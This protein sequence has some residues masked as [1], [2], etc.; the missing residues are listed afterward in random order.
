MRFMNATSVNVPR[1][2]GAALL[3]FTALLVLISASVLLDRLSNRT[4]LNTDR[5]L[6]TTA[7]LA[8]A[9]AALIAWSVT[10]PQTPGRL[11]YPDRNKDPAGYDGI[12][13]CITS[14][15]ILSASHLLGRLP[16]DG[17]YSP[18]SGCF[19]LADA[20]L[21]IEVKDAGGEPLWY[22]VSANLVVNSG[23]TINPGLFD[24]AS[25][26]Y[27]WLRVLDQNGN[28]ISDRAA[29]VV[30]AP[31]EAVRLENGVE[32]DRS[33]PAPDPVE[34]LDRVTVDG[35]T[36]DNSDND[37]VFIQYPDSRF[38]ASETDSFNDRLVYITIDELMRKVEKRVL[39]DAAV[40][41]QDY[42]ATRGRYPWLSPY[43]DPT[44]PAA[45]LATVTG[46]LESV[47]GKKI[48]D[49]DAD[50][51]N[52]GVEGGHAVVNVSRRTFTTVAN[53]IGPAQLELD[54]D[55]GFAAGHAYNVLP[56][57]NGI[58]GQREG[59]IPF[60]DSG[61]SYALAT[62]FSATW[63]GGAVSG[64]GCDPGFPD[65]PPGW[66]IVGGCTDVDAGLAGAAAG[67][68]SVAAP[69]VP[70]P[71]ADNGECIWTDIDTVD[72]KGPPQTGDAGYTVR[73]TCPPPS[74]APGPPAPEPVSRSY[75]VSLEFSGKDGQ[76]SN[77][78]NVKT[79][80]VTSDE[81]VNIQFQD[82]VRGYALAPPHT[83]TVPAESLT[84]DGI[85]FDI[86]LVEGAEF[87][88]YFFTNFW[89]RYI[90][91]KISDEHV[92][93]NDAGATSSD[94]CTAGTDCVSLEI[95][96]VTVRNE[97]QALVVGAGGELDRDLTGQNRENGNLSDYFESSNATQ[98]DDTAER[99]I[100][101]TV[102]NDQVRVIQPNP[103]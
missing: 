8:E 38:T 14:P 3:V 22:A 89:H 27:P 97:I 61:E 48:T 20:R 101:T 6:E 73:V 17:E 4:Q 77:V 43:R 37:L 10:H 92:A 72:C 2:A 66:N 83:V 96:G 81:D 100:L 7:A 82:S 74:C 39:G 69:A 30:I 56:A 25:P 49:D 85:Y 31:G 52:D 47:G 79:R 75:T 86:D 34:Y 55:I 42:R 21:G 1:Q 44:V 91:V 59:H 80:Q 13:D 15:G 103:P 64:P 36:Y 5:E 94:S 60:I 84:V 95:G 50:F 98:G 63:S 88:E 65:F 57:F 54:A 19:G 12:S 18:G 23:T 71:A 33:D 26:I 87:P 40:A 35:T 53:C 68:F 29:A 90:Y 99:G 67:S 58:W 11:P 102:F 70:T 45:P 76:I 24:A 41:L 28:I 46:R 16:R 78:G 9:K 62:G 32:Q 93:V 51:C